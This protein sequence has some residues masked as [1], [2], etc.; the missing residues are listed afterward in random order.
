M[1]GLL[2][3]RAGGER[4]ELGRG[5]PRFLLA[6][7]LCQPNRT[8]PTQRL[9]E[10]LWGE[11][12]PRTAAK[13]LQVNVCHLRKALRVGGD[14]PRVVSSPG[15][16]LLAVDREETDLGRFEQ[17]ASEAAAAVRRDELEPAD[18]LFR[19]A[20]AL[21]RGRPFEGMECSPVLHRECVRLTERRLAVAEAA[22]DTRLALGLHDEAL[23][24]LEPLVADHPFRERLRAQQM[25]ALYRTGR[26]AE[27]LFVF[28]SVRRMLVEELGLQPSAVLQRLQQ[29]VLEGRT[30]I[31]APGT[32][33]RTGPVTRRIRLRGNDSQLPSGA[34]DFVGRE[35]ASARL[36]SLLDPCGG[37]PAEWALTVV[38]GPA[39]TGKSALVNRVARAVCDRYPGG[40]L[41]A[42]LR[43]PAGTPCPPADAL[44]E[45]LRATGLPGEAVPEPA[46]D[47]IR[48]YRE[49]LHGSRTLVVLDNAMDEEQVKPLL[50]TTGS[51]VTVVTA[52][53]RLAGLTGARVVE[54]GELA[55]GEAV[56]LLG[57]V[58]GEH[59]VAA[60]PAAAAR[61]ARACGFLPLALRIAGARL[62]SRPHWS[63]TRLAEL[64]EGPRGLRELSVAG[65]DMT[66]SLARS[67]SGACSGD[68]RVTTELAALV[69]EFTSREAAEL[70][71][72]P[73]ARTEYLLDH[74]C[75]LRLLQCD[76]RGPGVPPRYRIPLLVRK[77]VRTGED[78]GVCR[79]AP[80]RVGAVDRG[81]AGARA[82]G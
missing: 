72:L 36:T 56:E 49:R 61:V 68:L 20:L 62:A 3:V 81:P 66:A 33:F 22:I 37:A 18:V 13:N 54:V 77:F 44:V 55:P 64:L 15:G 40:L 1:L 74:L 31:D 48:L 26:Q 63:L 78:A 60:E 58:A 69:T 43:T 17:L 41:Y 4:V 73:T 29:A 21:W 39:G 80:V 12:P 79:D 30:E 70:L 47:R 59:R 65:M 67:L 14:R 50:P 19:R 51:C 25:V 34:A 42:D 52:C 27:A 2:E 75:D 16:Y 71:E 46:A 7:L 23:Q 35:A 45:M 5:K 28:A 24:D 32:A 6:A 76:P 9:T 53:S 38:S 82:R 10:A 57:H 11:D 8:M